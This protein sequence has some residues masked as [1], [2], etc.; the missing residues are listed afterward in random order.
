MMAKSNN[1]AEIAKRAGVTRSQ[2]RLA[3][4]QA[5]YQMDMAQTDVADV[6]REFQQHRF[7][8]M[9]KDP[10]ITGAHPELF[11]T[12]VKGV[13]T[14]QRDIDPVLDQQLAEGWRLTRI[15]S[16]LR[17]LLRGAVFEF[18]NMPKTPARVVLNEYIEIARA[19][20]EGDEPKVANAVLDKIARKLRPA[21]F[22]DA[23]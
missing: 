21:E 17:A 9:G 20:F 11:E 12:I 8:E 5:L 14:L 6:V 15:D 10:A 18:M 3:A 22:P 7:G 19:F 13:V 1:P 16:I 23:K 4:V 2:A